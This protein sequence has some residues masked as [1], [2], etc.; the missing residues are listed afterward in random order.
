MERQGRDGGLAWLIATP[1]GR[2]PAV[3][4]RRQRGALGRPWPHGPVRRPSAA[5]GALGARVRERYRMAE[6]RRGSGSVA[7][8]ARPRRGHAPPLVVL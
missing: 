7:S 2:L 3:L 8:R 5:L 1:Q 6:T 4:G